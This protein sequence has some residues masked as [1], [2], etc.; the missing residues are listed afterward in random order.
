MNTH[1][2]AGQ[3]E[4]ILTLFRV[5]GNI[6]W[7]FSDIP[8]NTN[9]VY[10]RVYLFFILSVRHKWRIFRHSVRQHVSFAESWTHA[11][12]TDPVFLTR[13]I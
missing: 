11:G 2:T 6:V 8:I 3:R 12:K 9:T 13:R 5:P 10:Y 1:I 4:D 7:M